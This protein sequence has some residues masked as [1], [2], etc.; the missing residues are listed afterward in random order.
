MWCTES[1]KVDDEAPSGN[2]RFEPLPEIELDKGF[3]AQG[4][5]YSILIT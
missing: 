1:F 5:L 3:V 4:P 2:L